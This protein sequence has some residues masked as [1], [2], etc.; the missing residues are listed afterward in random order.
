LCGLNSVMA[1]V[2]AVRALVRDLWGRTT[3]DWWLDI[4]KNLAGPTGRSQS[5]RTFRNWIASGTESN[6]PQ[7]P[8]TISGEGFLRVSS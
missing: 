6:R 4:R 8:V 3:A 1:D 7:E 2:E 5:T